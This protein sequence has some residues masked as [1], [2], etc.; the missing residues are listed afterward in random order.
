M[1]RF[2]VTLLVAAVWASV[3]PTVAHAGILRYLDELSGPGPFKGPTAEFRGHC[4][5]HRK[6][7]DD[8]PVRTEDTSAAEL[9][10]GIL[11]AVTTLSSVKMACINKTP[12]DSYHR[13][14]VNIESGFL[15]AKKNPILYTDGPRRVDL[16]PIEAFF[17]WQPTLGLEIGTGGGMFFFFPKD[18]SVLPTVVIEPMRVD[19]RPFD[20]LWAKRTK[21]RMSGFSRVLRGVTF[22]QSFVYF[23]ER[24]TAAD[25]GGGPGNTFSV[26]G[27]VVKSLEFVFDV[28]P[29]FRKIE[30]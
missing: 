15:R 23:P 29:Y 26:K 28:M 16:V 6:I 21:D 7:A 3:S 20:V 2:L 4:W 1:K 17:Y 27:D 13:F 22:R 19:I 12:P 30:K 8:T 24:L 11:Q 14:S 5:G 10:G 9:I 18:R 25:F